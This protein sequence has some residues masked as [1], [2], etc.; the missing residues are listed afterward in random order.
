MFQGLFKRVELLPEQK[1]AAFYNH[2]YR[3]TQY[4]GV[5]TG[6]VA[7]N[8]YGV[9]RLLLTS[10][11]MPANSSTMGQTSACLLYLRQYSSGD[12]PVILLNT[13][14]NAFT[15]EYPTSYITSLMVLRLVSSAFFADSIFT[16]CE[17]STGV[18]P[19]ALINLRS[20]LRRPTENKEDN[21]SIEI[22][23]VT[24]FSIYACA[25]FTIS[26][27]CDFWPVKMVNAD[28]VWR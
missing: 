1:L 26:S 16:R 8:S 2:W 19:V 15:S 20:K 24:F 23:S 10:L 11:Y 25:F 3:S 6:G 12:M 9:C 28:C 5:A 7:F 21:C 27:P 22:F 13:S 18:L 17:Y 14:L 4:T